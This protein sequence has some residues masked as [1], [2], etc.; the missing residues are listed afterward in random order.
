MHKI[1]QWFMCASSDIAA[2]SGI[3]N[4][5]KN[6][7]KNFAQGMC[8]ELSPD[9][10]ICCLREAKSERVRSQ[11]H[12]ISQWIQYRAIATEVDVEWNWN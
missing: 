4:R 7:S 12:G 8:F 5:L 6:H 11:R 2:N 10:K 9:I 3:K 1:D